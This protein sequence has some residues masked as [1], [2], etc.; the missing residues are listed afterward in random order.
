MAPIS[1][2]MKKIIDVAQEDNP[3]LFKNLIEVAN[4]HQAVLLTCI[5]PYVGR[6]ISPTKTIVAQVGISE[7]FAIETVI[8]EIS[9]KTKVKN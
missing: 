9:Q 6:K 8:N 5:A 2:S 7:E 4:K 3:V 1:E